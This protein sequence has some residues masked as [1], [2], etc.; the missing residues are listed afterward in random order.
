MKNRSF[1][2]LL[3]LLLMVGIPASLPAKGRTVRISMKGPDRKT[4]IEITD[5]TTLASFNVW[6]GPG[7]SSNQGKG[8]IVDWSQGTVSAPPKGL[9]RYEVFFYADFGNNEEKPVYVVSYENDPLTRRGYVCLP[10]KG[11]KWWQLKVG[12]IFRS[13][14]GN[15]FSAWSRWEDVATPLIAK[16]AASFSRGGNYF[17]AAGNHAVNVVPVASDLVNSSRP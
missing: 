11:E 15:W 12:S 2:A 17:S 1:T 7:T 10:G 14:E 16:A 5:P 13:V 6:T 4:P 3:G 9:P 8:L